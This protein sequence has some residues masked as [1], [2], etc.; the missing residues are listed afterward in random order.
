[1]SMTKEQCA[2]LAGLIDGEGTISISHNKTQSEGSY[3]MVMRIYNSDKR[4]CDWVYKVVN[5]G[6]VSKCHRVKSWDNPKHKPI[7]HW[8]TSNNGMRKI[9]P[10]I[11]PFLV[12]KKEIAEIVLEWLEKYGRKKLSGKYLTFEDG[13]WK[14]EKYEYLKTLNY[15]GI[16]VNA[17]VL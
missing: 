5:I 1:M 14:K 17:I 8:H 15:R 7:Y 9:L 11:I 3:S 2:Y 12:I 13:Q 6:G 4:M 16:K 10:Q